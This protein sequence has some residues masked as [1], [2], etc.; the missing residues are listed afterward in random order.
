MY[1]IVPKSKGLDSAFFSSF[2]LLLVVALEWQ[3]ALAQETCKS[4]RKIKQQGLK[5]RLAFQI[6]KMLPAIH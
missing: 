3:Y 1:D 5:A 2:P 6:Q 4:K